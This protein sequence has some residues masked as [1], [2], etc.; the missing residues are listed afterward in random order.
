MLIKYI[1]KDHLGSYDV[2]TKENGQVVDSY[3]FDAWGNHRNYYDWELGDN[4][5]H[6]FDRGFTG[7][8]HLDKLGL[9]NMN[10]RLY[11]PRLARFLSPDSYVQAPDNTQNFNRY[12]YCLNNPLI[13]TDPSGELFWIIPNIGWSK[14]GGL[15]IGISLNIGIPGGLSAQ[16]GIGYSFGSNDIYGYIGTTV[17]INTIYASYSLKSGGSVGYTAGLSPFS[18]LPISTNLGTVGV[19]YNISYNRWSSNVSAWQV[20]QNGWS[21]NP[22]VSVMV[23]PEQTT[24]LARGQG[25][26]SNDAVLSRFVAAKEHQ[27]ALD[28]FGFKGKYNPNIKSKRYQSEDYWGA[29]NSKTGEISYGNLAFENYSTL[30]GTYIKESYHAKSFQNGSFKKLPSDLQGLGMDTYLEEIHG[31][32]YAYKRQG[33]FSGHNIPFKGVEFYQSQIGMC[34]V[35]YPTYP[36]R[37]SWIYKVPRKW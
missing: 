20:D 8:E 10:G 19:N 23:F 12:S 6:L 5:T 30:Y 4:T 2:V 13:Y 17:A 31:Y 33:L 3:S 35:T 26:R 7:H 29:T 27:E 15:S 1:Y 21:F 28:Y 34:G 24:N 36:S 16:V 32:V 22:S 9:I 14:E 18:G 11:D 25:F 37:F